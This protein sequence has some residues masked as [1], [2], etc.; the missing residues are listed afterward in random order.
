MDSD[1]PLVVNLEVSVPRIIMP[2]G[3]K[4]SRQGEDLLATGQHSESSNDEEVEQVRLSAAGL[5]QT[6]SPVQQREQRLISAREVST[7]MTH[8]LRF[9]LFQMTITVP[10]RGRT[11]LLQVLR[12]CST[13]IDG[14]RRKRTNTN[15]DDEHS[16]QFSITD[17]SAF[18]VAFRPLDETAALPSAAS[19]PIAGLNQ[20][21]IYLDDEGIPV[22]YSID[23]AES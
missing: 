21:I 22:S 1:T 8:A 16:G 7:R 23:G 19:P 3:W 17:T 6:P 12:K 2:T 4:R 5:Q 9:R 11:F 10:V 13:Y 14:E 18:S 20:V 15:K